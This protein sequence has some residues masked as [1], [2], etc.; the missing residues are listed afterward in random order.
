[1]I[2]IGDGRRTV[3]FGEASDRSVFLFHFFKEI[4]IKVGSVIVI[5]EVERNHG[6]R[7]VIGI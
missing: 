2:L 6:R 1:M 7:M 3:R 4:L 5:E